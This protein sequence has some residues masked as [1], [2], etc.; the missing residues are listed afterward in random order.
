MNSEIH[1]SETIT[2][3]LSSLFLSP[4]NVRR[5]SP[6]SIENMAASI[7][8]V[9]QLQNLIAVRDEAGKFGVI[10]GG[11]RLR[12]MQLLHERGELADD[13]PVKVAIREE[14]DST[15]VSLTENVERE[16]MH[17]ADEY[18]AFSKLA[19]AGQTID[20]IADAFGVTPLVV[21]RR[22]SLGN[23]SPTL[24][25][26]FRRDEI[27]TDQM[28]ALCSTPDHER[29]LAAWN[30]AP[31]WDRSAN[32]LR[33]MVTT[34][35]VDSK[36]DLRVAF[37]G[38]VQA[39]EAAGGTFRRDLFAE[40]GDGSFLADEG[41]LE[42]LF[43][44]KLESEADAVK[45]EGWAW[46]EV[47]PTYDWQAFN[48][49]GKVEGER[50]E[51]SA[52]AAQTLSALNEETEALEQE[53]AKI[54]ED[55]DDDYTDAESERVEQIDERLREI[56]REARCIENARPVTF[57]PEVMAN[58]GAMV[59]VEGGRL[60]ID[61]GLVKAADRKAMALADVS[62]EGGR[63]TESAGRKG[64]AMSDTLRRSLLGR[65]NHAVQMATARNT[66]VAKVLLAFQ[67]LDLI[68]REYH[69]ER[70]P[71]D[72]IL[73]DQGEGTRTNHQVTGADAEQLGDELA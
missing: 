10:V 52:E 50:G 45:A 18:E 65:R 27:S 44:A 31:R 21:E 54:D 4:A 35:E 57:P 24:I 60:R 72:L 30:G 26:M 6:T 12:G 62:I 23:A 14:T 64:N 47:S 63:E 70:A 41:L 61:R 32:Q 59:C 34:G 22:L 29:Q 68:D 42:S 17:P 38:G 39:Y 15:I 56:R 66:H 67:S 20:R 5:V 2:V 69:S 46:V 51:L 49:M 8:A 40:S 33:R 28:I 25:E 16:D 73:R 55:S 1:V 7:R 9:G 48:R 58:A 36:R 11:R 3:P 37:I 19:A 71:C 53:Q 43:T 13:F